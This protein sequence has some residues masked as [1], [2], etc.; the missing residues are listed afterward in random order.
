MFKNYYDV[1]AMTE[2]SS[3]EIDNK[4]TLFQIKFQLFK[5]ILY[6]IPLLIKLNQSTNE[7]TNQMGIDYLKI[8]FVAVSEIGTSGGNSSVVFQFITF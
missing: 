5:L 4:L 1:I 6:G 8:V 3:W 2:N 7:P